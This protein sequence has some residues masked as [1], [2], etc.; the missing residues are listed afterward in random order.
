MNTM[1]NASFILYQDQIKIREKHRFLADLVASLEANT[2]FDLKVKAQHLRIKSSSHRSCFL[3][4][5]AWLKHFHNASSFFDWIFWGTIIEGFFSTSTLVFIFI[6]H[7]EL[8]EFFKEEFARSS[9]IFSIVEI[10]KSGLGDSGF[11]V[12]GASFSYRHRTVDKRRGSFSG[13]WFA[14]WEERVHDWEIKN[15]DGILKNN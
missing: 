4:G 11:K 7:T 10:Y 1:K 8:L 2:L 14:R 12:E 13:W 15:G 5:T 6:V 3:D 9:I